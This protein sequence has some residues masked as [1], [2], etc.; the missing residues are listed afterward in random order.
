MA[1]IDVD[2]CARAYQWNTRVLSYKPADNQW[3]ALGD[4][5]FLPNCDSAIAKKD[6]NFAVVSGEIKPGLRTPDVKSL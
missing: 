5:P 4:N 1:A 3:S 2:H 6:D